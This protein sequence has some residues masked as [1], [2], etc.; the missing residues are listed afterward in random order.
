MFFK[1]NWQERDGDDLHVEFFGMRT[2]FANFHNDGKES[3]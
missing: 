2:T 1:D 3:R